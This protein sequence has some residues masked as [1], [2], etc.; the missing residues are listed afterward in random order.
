V[1]AP[2]VYVSDSGLLH[3]LLGLLV[4]RGRRRLG[5]EMKLAEAPSLTK[6]MRV[7]LQDLR[8][9]RLD[10]IHAGEPTFALAPKIRA[11]ALSRLIKDVAPLPSP[12]RQ[13]VVSS[14]VFAVRNPRTDK[15]PRGDRLP[16]P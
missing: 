6:S 11:V 5:F 3:A 10:V 14:G 7:A 4:V 15:S 9:A 12:D 8:L 2:K 1:K 16:R 13:S